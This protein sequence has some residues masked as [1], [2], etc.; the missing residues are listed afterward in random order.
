MTLDK[1]KRVMQRIRERNLGKD[2]VKRFEVERAIMFECGTD[3]RTYK[4]HRTTLLELGWLRSDRGNHFRLT[5]RDL[6][7]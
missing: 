2:R 7:Y 5:D 1:L 3:S 4:K 6:T